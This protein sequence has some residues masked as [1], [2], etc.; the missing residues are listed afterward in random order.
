MTIL[1]TVFFVYVKIESSF[2]TDE[3]NEHNFKI[4]LS[5]SYEIKISIIIFIKNKHGQFK[6][7]TNNI[8]RISYIENL[9]PIVRYRQIRTSS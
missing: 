3:K 5:I 7:H 9:F 4:L 1:Y 2:K 6:Q 8:E